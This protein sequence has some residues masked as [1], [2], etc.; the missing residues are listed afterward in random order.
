VNKEVTQIYLKENL[1]YNLLTGIFIWIKGGPGRTIS[2]EAGT[3]NNGYRSI[4]INDISYYS[5]RLAFLYVEGYMPENDVDHI[6]KIRNDNRWKNLRHVSRQCN[7][8]N[9]SKRS[10]NTSEVTGVHW[11]NN[12]EKWIRSIKV[13]ENRLHLGCFCN[14]IDAVKARWKAEVK[15]NFPNCNTTSLA[16]NYLN[17]NKPVH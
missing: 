10:D 13:G 5:H 2:K 4:V 14:F 8:R 7:V 12:N 1:E 17:K 9:L 11:N 15:H 16:C 6:N 3:L